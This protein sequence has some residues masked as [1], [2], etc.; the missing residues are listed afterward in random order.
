MATENVTDLLIHKP[1]FCYLLN[2][3]PILCSK[4]PVVILKLS[5]LLV[6]QLRASA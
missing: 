5:E 6:N 2:I 1:I 3:F 4:V